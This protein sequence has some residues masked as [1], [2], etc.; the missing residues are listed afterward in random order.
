MAGP[1]RPLRPRDLEGVREHIRQQL[2]INGTWGGETY[3]GKGL[4][5]WT[6]W[7]TDWSREQRGGRVERA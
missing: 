3:L 5:R 4:R 1:G 7:P 2:V 6:A